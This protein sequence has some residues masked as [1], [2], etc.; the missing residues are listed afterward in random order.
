MKKK[1]I[2]ILENGLLHNQMLSVLDNKDCPR[3]VFEYLNLQDLSCSEM[4][5]FQTKW[6][7]FM[8]VFA[9][10]AAS[11]DPTDKEI[12]ESRLS[13]IDFTKIM[14]EHVQPLLNIVL[15]FT[16]CPHFKSKVCEDL[17]YIIAKSNI[18]L[19]NNNPDRSLSGTHIILYSD[20][21]IT[22]LIS[23]H[24]KNTPK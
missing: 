20:N 9:M 18:F 10:W 23:N 11:H 4:D 8:K 1:I 13:K 3:N 17:A 2:S 21:D 16:K 19:V 6:P 5:F 24:E 12:Y 7:L 22:S 15:E 14:I